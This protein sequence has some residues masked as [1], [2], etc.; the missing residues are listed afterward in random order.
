MPLPSTHFRIR[1]EYR[2]IAAH[3]FLVMDIFNG[4]TIIPLRVERRPTRDRPEKKTLLTS[5]DYERV[6][7]DSTSRFNEIDPKEHYKIVVV[8]CPPRVKITL[9]DLCKIFRQIHESA[10]N[11]RLLSHQCYWF[12]STFLARL[13]K[14]AKP[15]QLEEKKMPGYGLQ[16][17]F[18]YFYKVLAASKVLSF[19][20]GDRRMDIWQRQLLR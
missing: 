3:E 10:P 11:Y 9:T 12:C 7:N 16:G 6:T 13:A 15:S 2:N 17:K 18:G 14:A 4:S 20:Q 8:T 19:K 5:Y 1:I